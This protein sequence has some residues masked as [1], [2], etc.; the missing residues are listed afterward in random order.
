MA[1]PGPV[2]QRVAVGELAELTEN[3]HRCEGY[4]CHQ[5][6]LRQRNNLA[7]PVLGKNLHPTARNQLRQTFGDTCQP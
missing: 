5:F 3:E 2:A 7:A 1:R 6:T 4:G